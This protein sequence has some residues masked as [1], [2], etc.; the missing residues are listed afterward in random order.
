MFARLLGAALLLGAICGFVPQL[1]V[2][3]ADI[4]PMSLDTQHDQLFRLFP[5]N[6]LDNIVHA[7]LGL[8]GLFASRSH[9]LARR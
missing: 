8:W 5:V 2:S 1:L 4:H 6:P 7:S 3:G 9:R